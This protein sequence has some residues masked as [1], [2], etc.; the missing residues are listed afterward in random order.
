MKE[1]NN[2]LILLI[3]LFL[4][5]NC[6]LL[7]NND[8]IKTTHYQ[9]NIKPTT[10]PFDTKNINSNNSTTVN[11]INNDKSAKKIIKESRA[12]GQVTKIKVENGKYLPDYYIYPSDQK[13]L[14]INYGPD[15]DLAPPTWQISW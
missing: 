8:S 4:I 2:C 14:N 10:L 7:R 13:K 3:N 5:S 1:K 12:N 6:S 15:K 11:Q 9:S